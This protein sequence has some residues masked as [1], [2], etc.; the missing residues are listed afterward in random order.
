[1]YTQRKPAKKKFLAVKRT[2]IPPIRM[3]QEEKELIYRAT[4]LS[5]QTISQFVFNNVLNAA[6][7]IINK[8]S[9]LVENEDYLQL[10]NQEEPQ[11]NNDNKNL[12]SAFATLANY[13][14]K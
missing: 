6:Q 3:T 10:L 11:S 9:I 12:K 5:G 2:T 7:N 8:N 1:M 13:S 4:L 14:G